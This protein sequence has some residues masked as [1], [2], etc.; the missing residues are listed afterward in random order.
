MVEPYNGKNPIDF[1]QTY[2]YI[3]DNY[4][5]PFP[6]V[7]YELEGKPLL[8]FFNE[9]NF[10]DAT[11]FYKDSR[12]T[13][14]IS[15]QKSYVDWIY[16]GKILGQWQLGILPYNGVFPVCPSFDDS[17]V[18]SPN[19]T[20]DVDYSNNSYIKD[21]NEALNYARNDQ[22][23]IITICSWNELEER[24][25][26][27]PHRNP[28]ATKAPFY[29]YNITK[30]YV[31]NL[32]EQGLVIGTP[33]RTPE[34]DVQPNQT[35]TVSV[36]VTD[37]INTILSVSIRYST[38]PSEA[39][40]EYPMTFNSNSG[41]YEYSIPGQPASTKVSYSIIAWD[42]GGINETNDNAGHYFTYSV[43]PEF[44]AIPSLLLFMLA[45]LLAVIIY[46]R[47][48]ILKKRL[49]QQAPNL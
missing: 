16:H 5:Q 6:S 7:Y 40:S 1:N 27:E 32:K 8:L 15:G 17:R 35:V 2:N 21:W 19:N 43:V 48:R 24:T 41:L 18:R 31:Y 37:F 11:T 45:T 13:I 33:S 4:V 29:L 10:T 46:N 39:M 30:S 25:A 49:G 28:N 42:S 14:K 36:N 22:V 34:G 9:D 26:I 23:D 38:N 3:H 20:V 47:K 12:F 44:P